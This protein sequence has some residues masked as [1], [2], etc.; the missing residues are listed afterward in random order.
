MT[1]VRRVKVLGIAA[2]TL[3]IILLFYGAQTHTDR[4][5]ALNEHNAE[6]HRQKEALKGGMDAEDLAIEKQLKS[7]RLKDAEEAAKAK[8][9]AKAPNPPKGMEG[10]PPAKGKTAG[11]GKWDVHVEIDE[12][13]KMSPIIIFSKTYCPYS[14]KA[15]RL[16][17]ETYKITPAPYVVELD[18]HDHGPAIQDE[19]EKMTGRRT[20]PNILV[21]GRSIG[22]GDDI[23]ELDADGKLVGKIKSL[24]GKAV[25]DVV[26]GK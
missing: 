7:Q 21:Q 2:F 12:I 23:A 15:K 19:L 3:I 10:V 26:K 6:R 5:I 18:E 24:G 8:A 4:R 22:G 16:L 14:K 9:N 17:L 20:V 11:A 1:A 25:Q 13:L